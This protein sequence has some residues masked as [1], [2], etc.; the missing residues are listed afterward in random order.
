MAE[1]ASLLGLPSIFPLAHRFPKLLDKRHSQNCRSQEPRS[2]GSDAQSSSIPEAATSRA[3]ATAVRHLPHQR[4][5][6]VHTIN[7]IAHANQR[8]TGWRPFNMRMRFQ[9]DARKMRQRLTT[10]SRIGRAWSQ[11]CFSTA[12]PN[13]NTHKLKQRTALVVGIQKSDAQGDTI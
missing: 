5:E 10:V 4:P 2:R 7:V 11:R 13:T 6:A 8:E 1:A 12:A 9:T 3:V